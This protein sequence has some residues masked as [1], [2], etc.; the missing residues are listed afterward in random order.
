MI[1]RAEILLK[2]IV[3]SVDTLKQRQDSDMAQLT[4][5]SLAPTTPN[6]ITNEVKTQ[7]LH[8]LLP[9]PDTID[10]LPFDPTSDDDR[11]QKEKSKIGC[12]PRKRT[13]N[14][15]VHRSREMNELE[16]RNT[17]EMTR[18]I[19]HSQPWRSRC[20]AFLLEEE[21]SENMDSPKY[22]SRVTLDSEVS[23]DSI[24]TFDLTGM[25]SS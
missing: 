23:D 15:N 24:S 3:K 8:S 10:G 1:K 19:S 7:S 6:S 17:V 14:R 13:K 12:T 2:Y 21:E 9:F 20:G 16:A 4:S 11:I 18:F 25:L 22:I 5:V